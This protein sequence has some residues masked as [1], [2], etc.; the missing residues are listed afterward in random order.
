[1]PYVRVT[2]VSYDP[3]RQ[4]ELERFDEEQVYPRM[5]QLPGFRRWL[6]H[7]SRHVP[8]D[9][10]DRHTV[11]IKIMVSLRDATRETASRLALGSRHPLRSATD[12]EQ[13]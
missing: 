1:M 7:G 2:V 6:D 4:E 11:D 13:S 3:T 12:R 5:R 8:D 9:S 10:D